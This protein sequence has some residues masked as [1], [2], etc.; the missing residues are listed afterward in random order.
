[1]SVYCRLYI[2]NYPLQVPETDESLLRE[3]ISNVMEALQRNI[4]SKRS[5]YKDKVLY[6]VFTMN[7]YW[8]IY[9]RTKKTEVGK[10][11]E[12]IDGTKEGGTGA[13]AK[14][15]IEAF[16]KGFEKIAQRH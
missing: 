9:M 1:M 3:A 11:L 5:G 14:G 8:H 13:A 6:H 15:K 2:V 16:L 10:L 4:E 7:T 12:E